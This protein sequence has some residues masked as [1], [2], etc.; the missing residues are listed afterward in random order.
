MNTGGSTTNYRLCAAVR[1]N[2]ITITTAGTS[3]LEWLSAY[4]PTSATIVTGTSTTAAGSLT[5]RPAKNSLASAWSLS[6]SNESEKLFSILTGTNDYVDVHFSVV[7]L[8]Q[9]PP[10]AVS[11]TNTGT[12]GQI[13][14]TYLDGPAMSAVFVPV[15]ALGLF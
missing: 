2:K 14:R 11:T 12:L 5:Q 13:Y 4:G 10:V 8:D 3:S 6:G 9:E 15:F 1:V 7:L